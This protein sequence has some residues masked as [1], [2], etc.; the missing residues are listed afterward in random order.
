MKPRGRIESV[1]AAVGD[2]AGALRRRRENRLPYV[3]LHGA[4]GGVRALD[5]AGAVAEPLLDAAAAM[6]DATDAR[7]GPPLSPDVR[8]RSR[9]SL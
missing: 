6:I 4:D 1:S 3:R 8:G 5:P 2:L 7:S 9:D